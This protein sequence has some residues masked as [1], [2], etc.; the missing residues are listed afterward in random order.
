MVARLRTLEQESDFARPLAIQMEALLWLRGASPGTGERGI[1]PMLD[2]L[3]DLE[4]EHWKKVT[5][6]VTAATLDRGVA[7]VTVVQGV[8]GRERAIALVKE[9][10]AYFGPRTTE[11]AAAVVRGLA[12]LYGENIQEGPSSDGRERLGALEPDLI[13]E[14]HV[15]ATTDPDLIESCRR[16]IETE[17]SEAQTK[18][19]RDLL[20]MLQRATQPE[21]GAKANRA[22]SGLLGHL[23]KQHI[24]P[25]ATDMTALARADVT[26]VVGSVTSSS[27]ECNRMI[28]KTRFRLVA[29]GLEGFSPLIERSGYMIAKSRT[30]IVSEQVLLKPKKAWRA[31]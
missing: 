5:E 14:H 2:R 25:F 10:S 23:I 6:G 1:A 30:A 21:H 26:I 20:T 28:P 24:K 16:W 17:S 11:T 18:R 7:Q 8:E 19:R 31:V 12:K 29:R 9:D 27:E 15:A 4:R 22:A 13:G 3:V